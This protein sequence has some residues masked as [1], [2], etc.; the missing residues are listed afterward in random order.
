MGLNPILIPAILIA[1][2][3]H[4]FSHGYIAYKCG[5]PTAKLSGRLTLNPIP[6]FDLIGTTM[7]F[8]VGFGWAKPVPV[9]FM[10]LNNPKRDIVLVAAAGPASNFILAFLLAKIFTFFNIGYVNPQSWVGVFA[11]LMIATIQINIVLA[12]FNLLPLYPLDGFRILSGLL[13]YRYNNIISF[14]E[15]Y[16]PF[17]FIGIILFSYLTG[18]RIIG[19]VLFPLVNATLNLFL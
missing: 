16:G 9:N 4:E 6:H 10:N 18:M 8:L 2:T 17:L 19:A 3:I 1:I 5:D 11:K 13:P 7:L 15:Y 14:L 12:W